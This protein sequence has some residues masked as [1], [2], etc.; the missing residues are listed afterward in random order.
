[1]VQIAFVTLFLG[2]TAGTQ[3]VELSVSGPV[4]VIELVLDGTPVLRLHGPP[5]RSRIDLGTRLE[6]HELVARALNSQGEEV[7]R[8]SQWLN[9]P[10]P[11]AEVEVVL[12]RAAG[13]RVTAAKIAWQSLTGAAPSG[14]GAVLDGNPL[15]LDRER[16]FP[17]PPYDPETSHVLTVTLQFADGLTARKDVVFGG[18]YGEEVSSDLT[19]VLVGLRKGKK[20]PPVEQLQGWFLGAG[21]PLHVTAVEDGPA[22]LLVIRDLTAIEPLRKL[23]VQRRTKA[24]VDEA[25]VNPEYLRFHMTLEPED[26]IHLVWTTAKAY[27][28]SSGLPAEL[29]DTTRPYKAKDGGLFWLL[30]RTVQRADAPTSPQ[31]LADAVAVAGLRAL[32]GNRRRAV[33]LML[34]REPEDASRSDPVLVRQYFKTVRVPLY[35][36]TVLKPWSKP[37]PGMAAW[38]EIEDA[39]SL[40]KMRNAFDRLKEDL[41]SQILI[42]VDGRH[43]PQSITLS[44]AA[45]EV[46]ELLGQ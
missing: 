5:W 3:P 28:G 1:M 40:N 46:V 18:I 34:A 22:E 10:R 16:R 27:A 41:E 7:G 15:I 43:L 13:G 35:V 21:R 14:I 39:S 11:P 33:L 44:P 31:R 45:A 37:P 4:A 20:L 17:I 8:A 26:E 19:G 42:W 29:F 36:W 6:P 23:E 2:L 9:L 12:E 32:E 30:S 25:K 24:I 38:G